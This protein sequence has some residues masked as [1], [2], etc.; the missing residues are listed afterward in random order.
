MKISISLLVLLTVVVCT[1]SPKKLSFEDQLSKGTKTFNDV[2]K[3]PK[4]EVQIIYGEVTS[5]SIRHHYYNLDSDKYFYPASTV[6]MLAAFAAVNKLAE[7]SMSFES[8]ISQDSTEIHPRK[9]MF[10][11]LF[12]E[13]E[14][15]ENLLKQIFV[16]SDNRAYNI[17]FSWLGKD[18]IN[19]F[20][21]AKGLNTRVVHQLSESAFSFTKE[22]NQITANTKLS[23]TSFEQGKVKTYQSLKQ[24]FNSSLNPIDQQKGRG[25]ANVDGEIILEPFDFS[26][27]NYVPLMDLLEALERMT[28]PDL[29]NDQAGFNIPDQSIDRLLKIM[30]LRPSNLPYPADT[31]NDN[32]VKFL[33]MGDKTDKSYSENV[34]IR[35]KVGWA[36]GYLTDVAYIEDKENGISFFLAATIHVNENEI[37]NDGIYQYESVG[38]PFLGEL[39]RLVHQLELANKNRSN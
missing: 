22:S 35:N 28:R 13:S 25:Y 2:L 20:F 24:N 37:Y 11:S 9:V 7:D 17:L 5:D 21:A 8:I 3:N 19:S 16:L 6:K 18:Y 31:L 27:K 32:Y 12:N 33:M 29:F 15:I 39:G 1:C 38:L 14:S 34:I 4:H 23:D 30:A 26:A 36:Y 10:D